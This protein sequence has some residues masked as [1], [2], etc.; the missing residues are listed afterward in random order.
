[1]TDTQEPVSGDETDNSIN[2]QEPVTNET[3]QSGWEGLSEDNLKY[4]QSK[5]KDVNA[6]TDS[7]RNLEKQSSTKVSIPADGDEEG[8]SKL[9]TKLGKPASAEEYD[10]EVDDSIKAKVQNLLL[11]NHA[12]KKQAAGLVDGYNKILAEHQK[13]LQEKSEQELQDLVTEWGDDAAKNQELMTRGKNL[14][15]EVFGVEDEM[16]ETVEIQLGTKNFANGL[17][18]LAEMFSED[19][20]PQGSTRPS[21]APM[22]LEE[23]YKSL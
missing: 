18:K 19:G 6:L 22:D 5:F 2:P 20:L 23:Y 13:A 11:A 10:I 16:L 17:K 9:Y 21:D 1:M 7:Y 8:A 14:L 12:T 15:G 3:P 4:V